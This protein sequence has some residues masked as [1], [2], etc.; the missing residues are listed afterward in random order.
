MDHIHAV[1]HGAG[2]KRLF[3]FA[4]DKVTKLLMI[5]DAIGMMFVTEEE[6]LKPIFMDCLLVTKHTG[7]GLM[8]E[9]YEKT[10]VKKVGLTPEEIRNQ[11]SRVAFDGQSFSLKAPEALARMMVEIAKGTTST[12]RETQD[13]LEWLLCTWDPAHRSEL[14]TNDIRVDRHGVDVELISVP[15]F[16]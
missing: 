12:T 2:R 8:R 5:G 7:R 16:A 4:A 6:E 14:V 15:W 9:I 13:F 10:F 3:A 1:N 11:C